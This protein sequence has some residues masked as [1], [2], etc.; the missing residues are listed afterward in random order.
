MELEK[1]SEQ[2]LPGREQG[3]GERVGAGAGGRNDPNKYAHVNK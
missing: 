2:V 3:R 1:I